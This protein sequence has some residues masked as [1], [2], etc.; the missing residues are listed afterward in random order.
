M[1]SLITILLLSGVCAWG[2]TYTNNPVRTCV[3]RFGNEWFYVKP[4]MNE[5]EYDHAV[6]LEKLFSVPEK[7]DI[8]GMITIQTNGAT[9]LCPTNS[10]CM[11]AHIT[12]E[13]VTN[14]IPAKQYRDSF[15]TPYPDWKDTENPSSKY[16]GWPEDRE[17]INPDKRTVEVRGIVKAT[18][19]WKGKP[20]SIEL[21]NNLLRRW[22]ER[23]VVEPPAPVKERWEA[24]PVQTNFPA[25]WPTCTN[26]IAGWE[27]WVS[28]NALGNIIIGTKE[29]K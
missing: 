2:Q 24:G 15:I 25:T 29:D 28:T 10:E 11:V 4:M 23:R 16:Y 7:T 9:Q 17:R 20:F 13:T 1:K 19:T 5:S 27:V 26:M 6:R 12:R 18:L 3:E 8:S 22:E 14:T 21:E